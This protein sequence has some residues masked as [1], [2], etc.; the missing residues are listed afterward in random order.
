MPWSPIRVVMAP[1]SE[2]KS[3]FEKQGVHRGVRRTVSR[4]KPASPKHLPPGPATLLET[5]ATTPAT[6]GGLG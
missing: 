4:G 5:A 1:A 3:V 2:F 6:P